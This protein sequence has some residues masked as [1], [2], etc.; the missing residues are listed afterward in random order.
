M[1]DEVFEKY[2][3]YILDKKSTEPAAVSQSNNSLLDF[4]GGCTKETDNKQENRAIDE[5]GDIF[6]NE[7]SSNSVEILKPVSLIQNGKIF[8]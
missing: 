3:Q 8:S 6:L 1:L 5:L 4:A 7:S 2:N